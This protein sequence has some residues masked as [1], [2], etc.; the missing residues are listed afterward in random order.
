MECWLQAWCDQGLSLSSST[1]PPLTPHKEDIS[2]SG[3]IFKSTTMMW[4]W[5]A[6]PSVVRGDRM[7]VSIRLSCPAHESPHLPL[8]Q[9]SQDFARDF[10][11]YPSLLRKA[12][13]PHLIASCPPS[14]INPSSTQQPETQQTLPFLCFMWLSK[15]SKKQNKAILTYGLM[16]KT[17]PS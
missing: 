10:Q 8:G 9:E 14:L 3:L 2:S 13:A 4:D 16:V 6:S 15:Q 7:E 5:H 1:L 12:N 11:I 17:P